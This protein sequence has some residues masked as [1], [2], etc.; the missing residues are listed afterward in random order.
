VPGYLT[1][2]AVE[3]CLTYLANTYPQI[4]SRTALPEV[5]PEG[6]TSHAIK[7]AHGSSSAGRRGV[8]FIAGVHAR[9]LVNPDLAVA[10]ALKL[11]QAYTGNTG[12]TFGGKSYTAG[13]VKM[14]VDTLDTI[15][16]PLVNPDGRAYVQTPGGDSWWRKNRGTHGGTSCVGVD[17]NRNFDFLWSSGIGTSVDPCEYQIYR[18][19]SP[20]SEPETR[21]VRSLLDGHA[22]IVSMIDIH[23]YSEDFL[24]PWGDDENQS[25]NTGMNFKNA[26]YNGLR[27]VP[28]DTQYKE[29]IPQ[30]DWD[31]FVR[32]ANRVVGAI[33]AARGHTYVA[34]ESIGLYPTTGTSDDYAYARHFVDAGKRRIYAYTLE[35]GRE[36]QPPYREA[37]EIINEVSAG[38]VEFLLASICVVD[39]VARTSRLMDRL[40]DFHAIRERLARSKT[41]RAWIEQLER[42]GPALLQAF[43]ADP[44][45]RLRAAEILTAAADAVGPRA[46]RGSVVSKTL[47]AQADDLA[48]QLAA[49]N[50]TLAKALTPFRRDVKR[51]A[52]KSLAAGLKTLD[53]PVARPR[54]RR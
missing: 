42:N 10:F 21:N 37:L 16:F 12:L 47:V 13:N 7:I 3:Q 4:V 8:L 32:T 6:R 43:R 11:C 18:G 38:L 50:K 23:S 19:P 26:T 54:P 35:T 27:G 36:F 34:K 22:N 2:T 17:L 29:Y 31:W 41:G 39:E 44:K 5:S 45:L 52:G 53:S 9:E 28:G 33:H 48:K 15:I 20:F 25:S 14:I 24:Y 40:E 30:P 46:Q 51:L 1:A 49:R